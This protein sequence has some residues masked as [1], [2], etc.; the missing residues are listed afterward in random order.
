MGRGGTGRGRGNGSP[1][2]QGVLRALADLLSHQP[3]GRAQ[4][5]ERGAR[6]KSQEAKFGPREPL[7]DCTICG[8]AGTFANRAVCRECGKEPKA[9][10][11]AKPATRATT[12]RGRVSF[13]Q[14]VTGK[15]SAGPAAG[16]GSSPGLDEEAKRLATAKEYEAWARRIASEPERTQEMELAAA[17]VEAAEAAVAAKRPLATQLRSSQDR[18]THRLKVMELAT[19]KLGD[20]TVSRDLAEAELVASATALEEVER[21]V[22]AAQLKVD[23]ERLVASGATRGSFDFTQQRVHGCEKLLNRLSL[24]LELQQDVET[25]R[26]LDELV[27]GLKVTIAPLLPPGQPAAAVETLPPQ[28]TESADGATAPAPAEPTDGGTK[29]EGSQEGSLA[30]GTVQPGTQQESQGSMLSTQELAQQLAQAKGRQILEAR[31]EMSR[32]AAVEAASKEEPAPQE[33]ETGEETQEQ[34]AEDAPMVASPRPS[35]RVS[36]SPG[37]KVS[38]PARQARAVKH[39]KLRSRS[40]SPEEPKANSGENPQGDG[41]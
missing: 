24:R 41:T 27:H 25:K 22:A 34:G 4:S 17:R 12:P 11:V 10:Q 8:T 2:G 32:A 28:S 14:A 39:G 20:L 40:R 21:E 9:A 38:T 37:K 19:A 23:Q 31:R 36:P 26:M 3:G 16:T 1:D 33:E 35:C 7:W 5:G 13:A 29:A 15:H 30:E 18:L 6:Q